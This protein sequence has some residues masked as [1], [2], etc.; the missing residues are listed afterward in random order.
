M[1]FGAMLAAAVGAMAPAH[2]DS[3]DS[4]YLA[5]LKLQGITGNRQDLIDNGHLICAKRRAGM[6]DNAIIGEIMVETGLSKYDAGYM[7]GAAEAAYCPIYAPGGALDS[8]STA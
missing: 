6:S 4:T 2:A 1:A 7:D 5:T 8:G 3:N